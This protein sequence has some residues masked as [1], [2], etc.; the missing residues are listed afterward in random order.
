MVSSRASDGGPVRVLIA[1]SLELRV[2]D[3]LEGRADISVIDPH[4]NGHSDPTEPDAILYVGT[5]TSALESDIVALRS[6]TNAPIVVATL[7]SADSLLDAALRLEVADVLVLPQT[8]DSLAF[9]MRKAARA[10]DRSSGRPGRVITVFSPKGGTGKSVISTN[11]AVAFGRGGLRTLLI[12]L[13][14]QFGD[15]AMMLGVTPRATIHDLAVDSGELDAD[16]LT[17]YVNAHESGVAV[18]AAPARPEDAE[19]IDDQT[20][21]RLL[22]VARGAYDMVIVDTSPHFDSAMLTALETTD[23]LLLVC[24]PEVTTLKNVRIGM[25]TL[26]RLSLNLDRMALVLNREG[27]PEALT[28]K[29]VE[30]AL[31][32]SIRFRVPNDSAVSAAVNRSAP[33]EQL[34]D[35]SAFVKAIEALAGQ[36]TESGAL[37]KR[38]SASGGRK[39]LGNGISGRRTP[40]P[41]TAKGSK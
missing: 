5:Q 1:G 14:L 36:L 19:A 4:S 37:R 18:L 22:K 26:D 12:D 7:A 20:L 2:M 30:Y 16:K 34:D 8:A 17:G 38:E 6:W 35:G 41:A 24:V 21:R 23:V 28:V 31:E 13:D 40:R 27:M 33:I 25:K 15:S 3:E 39:L 32:Q 10:A 9:A 29:E 11:L